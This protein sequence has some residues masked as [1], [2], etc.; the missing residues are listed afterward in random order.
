MHSMHFNRV[1]MCVSLLWGFVMILLVLTVFMQI[2]LFY[3]LK[4]TWH[5]IF[6]I[7]YTITMFYLYL[8]MPW[9]SFHLRFEWYM[10]NIIYN[11]CIRTIFLHIS[12][13]NSVFIKIDC[14]E[15]SLLLL[16][17]PFCAKIDSF[18]L[19]QSKIFHFYHVHLIRFFSKPLFLRRSNIHLKFFVLI[20]LSYHK[21]HNI[22]N[23]LQWN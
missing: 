22:Y 6:L 11:L 19:K 17:Y 21:S 1:R 5:F 9:S 7:L 13:W 20:G 14:C 8:G 15:F 3:D 4:H 12:S 23:L 18:S 2:C 16:L 10:I